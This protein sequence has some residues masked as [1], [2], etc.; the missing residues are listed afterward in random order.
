MTIRHL[1]IF[2]AVAETGKMNTAADQLYISQPTVSQAVR[3][4]EAH[5]NT[6]LFER[7]SKRLFITESGK[8]L[9]SYARKVVRDFDQLERDM[10]ASTHKEVLRLGASITVGTCLLPFLLHDLRK[11]K[12]EIQVKTMVTNTHAIEELLLKSDLDLAVVEGQ[13]TSP[14]LVVIPAV[15]D[16]LVMACSPSH[17]FASLDQIP[18]TAL[19]GQDFAMREK[20]SGTRAL[21]EY[22]LERH[23]IKINVRW[24]ANCPATIRQAI[25]YDECLSV[26]SVRLL[27]DEIKAGKIHP[28]R[29]SSGEWDRKF[30]LVYH[31]NKLLT[32]SMEYFHEILNKYRH[33]EEL[34]FA[35]KSLLI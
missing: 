14:D 11:E 3:E 27:T 28:I 23:G 19:N 15:E 21:F 31:K 33:P 6:K 34:G 10:Q 32:T 1:K 18:V 17:P 12:P 2:L 29:N 30:S 24:E 13:I 5:Y 4:L 16:Y 7:L 22:F 35:G 25:L 20:G 8:E 26:M 9:L